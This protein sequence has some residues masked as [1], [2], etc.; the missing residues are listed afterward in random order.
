LLVPAEKSS[1]TACLTGDALPG[2][3]TSFDEAGVGEAAPHSLPLRPACFSSRLSFASFCRRSRAT[4][5][6]ECDLPKRVGLRLGLPITVAL[7][8]EG[9]P[10][11]F[12]GNACA[13]GLPTGCI[14]NALEPPSSLLP[15]RSPVTT[16]NFARSCSNALMQSSPLLVVGRGPD[17]G[18]SGVKGSRSSSGNLEGKP[19]SC[20]RP[21]WMASVESCCFFQSSTVQPV[22]CCMAVARSPVFMDSFSISR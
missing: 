6:T 18:A 17:E 14:D 3:L 20:R 21:L 1:N 9:V 4:E 13:P 16:E 19:M 2:R 10:G 11:N 22:D 12:G 15:V 7:V 5:G 8:R